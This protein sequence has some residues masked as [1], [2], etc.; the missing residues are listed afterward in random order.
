ML[1]DPAGIEVE[2]VPP[3]AHRKNIV[4]ITPSNDS[5]D[6]IHSDRGKCWCRPSI[7]CGGD[8]AW[9][10]IHQAACDSERSRST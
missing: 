5:R 1:H 9:Y 3:F 10:V 8:G 6:H 2:V 4:H 7:E